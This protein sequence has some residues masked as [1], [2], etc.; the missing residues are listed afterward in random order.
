MINKSLENSVL[1]NN[2]IQRGKKGKNIKNLC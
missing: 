2:N 1:F